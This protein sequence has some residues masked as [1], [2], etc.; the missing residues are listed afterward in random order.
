MLLLS[1]MNQN[2]KTLYQQYESAAIFQDVYEWIR[3]DLDINY[4]DRPISN[5]SY[6]AN[7]ENV[8]EVC[9]MISALGTGITG[10]QMVEVPIEQILGQLPKET[11]E[12]L[13]K[14]IEKKIAHIKK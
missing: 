1:I 2:K 14:D 5:Y 8:G 11:W 6:M 9:R 3:N 4:P 12:R 13:I 10:F 7:T